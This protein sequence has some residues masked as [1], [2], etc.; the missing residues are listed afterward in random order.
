MGLK[1]HHST[2]SILLLTHIYITLQKS[3]LAKENL[4]QEEMTT[5]LAALNS[6]SAAASSFTFDLN[7]LPNT[8]TAPTTGFNTSPNSVFNNVSP[9]VTSVFAPP[10]AGSELMES[11]E[12]INFGAALQPDSSQIS[13]F[14]F[15]LKNL[16]ANQTAAQPPSSSSVFGGG[17]TVSKSEMPNNPNYSVISELKPEYLEAFRTKTFKFGSLPLDPPPKELCY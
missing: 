16:N 6:S 10:Q 14:S 4:Q 3:L 15:D 12:P 17:N 13:S 9:V 11:A 7:A 5:E 1:L 8:N 2:L